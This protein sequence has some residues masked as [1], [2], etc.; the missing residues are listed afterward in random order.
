[1]HVGKLT[2]TSGPTR[3]GSKIYRNNIAPHS[4]RYVGELCEDKFNA[5]LPQND[6]DWY[7]IV[8]GRYISEMVE[9]MGTKL[10]ARAS[11]RLEELPFWGRAQ[12]HFKRR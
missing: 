9:N 5:M 12:T 11:K 2:T 10:H 3:D 8:R 7:S 1:M 6:Y 4:K